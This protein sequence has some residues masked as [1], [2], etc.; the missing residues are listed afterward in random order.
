MKKAIMPFILIV[1]IVPAVIGIALLVNARYSGNDEGTRVFY[2]NE[3]TG[4]LESTEIVLLSHSTHAQVWEMITRFYNPPAGLTGLWPYGLGVVDITHH[5]Y[6][7]GVALPAD[8]RGLTL[9]EQSL[10]RA[11]L[12]L[13]LTQLPEVERVVFWVHG[14]GEKPYVHF[15]EWIRDEEYWDTSALRIE[16][17][18]TVANNPTI[19]PGIMRS[20]TITLYFVD[21]YDEGLI[22]ETFVDGYVD[23]HRLAEEKLR[24]L[25]SGPMYENAQR[26]IPPETRIRAVTVDAPSNS[27]YVDFSEDFYTR[28]T[29]TPEQ[30]RLMLQSIVNTLTLTGNNR[31]PVRYAFFLID[32]H[33]MDTFHGVTGFDLAFV[34]D[35]DIILVDEFYFGWY[36]G[37][38]E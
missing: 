5:E 32:S 34:Y 8:F 12:T 9:M 21:A 31:V 14:E 22:T 2:Y 38:D 27:I 37:E 35:H 29:G 30:A 19:S 25:I 26:L 6:T 28:F 17:L 36:T 16:S 23:L 13:T 4:R 20:R 15:A 3:V 18:A 10:L 7:V 1:A 33:R 24:Y 11:G